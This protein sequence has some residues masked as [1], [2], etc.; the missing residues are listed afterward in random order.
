MKKRT[1]KEFLVSAVIATVI[2]VVWMSLFI[3]SL[4]RFKA[5]SEAAIVCAALA[6]AA[7]VINSM[8]NWIRYVKF[9]EETEE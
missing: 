5:S 4:G 3:W 6:L 2:T 8:I 1:K 7:Q 9:E